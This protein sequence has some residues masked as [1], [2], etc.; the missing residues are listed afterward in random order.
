MFL[1][2]NILVAVLN[3][4]YPRF[5]FAARIL[6]L[7]DNPR[8]TLYTSRLAISI[9]F[10][11][12]AKKANDKV[13]YGKI[14]LL[15]TKVLLSANASSDLKDVFVNKKI[16]DIED[17]LEYFAALGS[18]STVIVTYDADDFYFS[19]IEVLSPKDFLI[20]YAL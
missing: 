3:N 1:D 11:F 4:E 9:S 16:H 10:Y 5:D 17:G 13:A 12:C 8:F 15:A 20:K 6:S 14:K 7:A 18:K 2:A 19:D